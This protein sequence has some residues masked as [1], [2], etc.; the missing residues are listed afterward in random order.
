MQ[1]QRE[2]ILTAK[3][4]VVKVGTSS[5]THA[6]GKLNLEQIDAL[7]REIADIHHRG[8]EIILVSSGAIAAGLGKLGLRKSDISLSDKQAMAAIGQN[9][10]MHMYRKMFSEYGIEIGQILLTKEDFDSPHRSALCKGT[11]EALFRYDVLPIINENDAVAV[12]EIKVGDNDTLSALVS[13]IISADLLIILS[14]IDGLYE[15]DPR[16]NSQAKLIHHVTELSEAVRALA[17]DTDNEMATGGMGT[18][19]SAIEIAMKSHTKTVIAN[20]KKKHIL[21]DIL[22]GSIVGTYFD[23]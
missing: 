13:N 3:K 1:T 15:D 6:S 2:S 16:K 19:I 12:E 5:L 22:S 10:L 8:I 17:R 18:K 11:L 21:R 23:L 9:I 20:G 14:D 7:A 4:I